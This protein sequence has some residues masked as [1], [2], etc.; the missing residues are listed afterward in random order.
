MRVVG[1]SAAD[2]RLRRPLNNPLQG[3]RMETGAR[4]MKGAIM[5]R[6]SPNNPLRLVIQ[7]SP[8]AGM[9]WECVG[10]TGSVWE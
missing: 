6:A 8:Y 10:M 4:K 1:R 9:T 2:S 5:G 3:M 7:R